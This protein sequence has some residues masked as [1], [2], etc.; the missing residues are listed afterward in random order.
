MSTAEQSR[1]RREKQRNIGGCCDCSNMAM[2]D[3][4]RCFKCL[5]LDNTRT[6]LYRA[7]YPEKIRI[8]KQKETKYRKDNN[9]CHKYGAP[10]LAGVDAERTCINCNQG[11]VNEGH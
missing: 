1:K 4:A 2:P 3:K 10:L 5:E 8:L 11:V 7:R 9:L 6:S